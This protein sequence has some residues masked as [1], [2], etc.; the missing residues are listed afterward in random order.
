MNIE[1]QLI[2]PIEIR[3]QFY[4]SCEESLSHA[5]KPWYVPFTQISQRPYVAALDND[6]QMERGDG[7]AVPVSARKKQEVSRR[8]EAREV[9]RSGV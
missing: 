6:K 1:L 7:F 8:A 2:F 5:F 4:R 9:V 3:I